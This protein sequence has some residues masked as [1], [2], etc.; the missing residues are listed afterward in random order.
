MFFFA[1]F[2]LLKFIRNNVISIHLDTRN[3]SVEMEKTETGKKQ[4]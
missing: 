1:F 4:Q 3:K 2:R